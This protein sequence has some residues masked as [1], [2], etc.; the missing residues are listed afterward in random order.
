MQLSVD[1]PSSL[2]HVY[3]CTTDAWAH[4][5]LAFSDEGCATLRHPATNPAAAP[6]ACNTAA[7]VPHRQRRR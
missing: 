5:C 6:A 3:P 1:I 2:I 4:S 7:R